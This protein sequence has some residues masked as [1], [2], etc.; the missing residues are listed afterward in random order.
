MAVEQTVLIVVAVCF[1][2][3]TGANDGSSVLSA[4]LSLTSLRTAT[5]TVILVC[6]VVLVPALLGTKVATT[7]TERL[8][9]FDGGDGARLMMV[10]VVAAVLV[11]AALA[12]IGLPTSLTLAVIGGI[13][14]AGLGAGVVVA[15][16]T[17]GTVLLVGLAAPM[18]GGLL[19]YGISALFRLLPPNRGLSA[20]MDQLH[21]FAFAV[22]CLAYSLNDAQKMLAVLAIAFGAGVVGPVDAAPGLLAIMGVCFAVGTLLGLPRI[23]MK[24]SN[25]LY[26][27]R[28]PHTVAA[29]LAAGASVLA[30]AAIGI[31]VSMTQALTG[32]LVGAGVGTGPARVRWKTA[33]RLGAAWVVTLPCSVALALIGAFALEEVSR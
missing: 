19:A 13:V 10:A 30:S 8:V 18:V 6:L 11:V 14:G 33:M 4:G 21:R 28:A 23:G 29:E 1:A 5:A 24:L 12:R 9:D 31:P 2:V 25:G 22:Q 3:V 17:V 16:S 15:W 7:F 20:A 27:V 26:A 32:G